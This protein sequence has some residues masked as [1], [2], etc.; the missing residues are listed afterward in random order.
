MTHAAS[1]I[2]EVMLLAAQSG[3]VG[4]LGG[5]WYC[6]IGVSPLFETIED[7]NRI[8]TVLTRLFDTPTYR[9][10]LR[11][12]GDRQ[13]IMLGYSDSCKDGGIWR[14]LGGYRKHSAKLLLLQ[15]SAVSN[16]Y[17]FMAV[18][19][20]LAVAAALRTKRFSHNPRYRAW[21]N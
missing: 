16:A 10:L 14:L 13:E 20:P 1:H 5:R 11:V 6:H 7:L 21:T 12:S 17:C 15:N 2:M 19:V 9:E 3:L 4:R 18:A 8:D